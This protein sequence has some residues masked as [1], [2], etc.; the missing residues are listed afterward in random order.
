MKKITVIFLLFLVSNFALAQKSEKIKGSK[1]ILIEQK[2]IGSFNSLEVGD[3]FEVHFEKGE[4]SGVK[5]EADENLHPVITLELNNNH[6]RIFTSKTITSYKKLILRITYT[7]DFKLITI[8]DEVNFN[9]IKEIE[10]D[11]IT[12]KSFDNSKLYLNANSKKFTL[13]ADNNSKIELNLKSENTTIQLSKNAALK[14]LVT[15]TDFKCDLYQKSKATLEGDITNNGIIRLD[16]NTILTANNLA[17]K[18]AQLIA[19]SYSDCSV[20]VSTNLILDASGNSKIRLYG[21]QKIEMKRFL[22]N[23]TL[24]KKPTK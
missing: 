5:V 23:A 7:D 22:D 13:L 4:K 11:D 15:S 14:A 20:N 19:E 8:K 10:L 3:N 16:N 1:I 6:L 21:D 2:E 12:L 18:N 17:I 9:A 24:N